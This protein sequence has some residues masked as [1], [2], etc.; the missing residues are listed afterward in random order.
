MSKKKTLFLTLLCLLI[1]ILAAAVI[2]VVFFAVYYI[3]VLK[4][5]DIVSRY[6][7]EFE[8]PPALI[9]AVI[10]T[11]SGGKT[12]KVSSKGACGLMQ[13]MPSTAEWFCNLNGYTYK[14]ENLFDAE[15]NIKLG[16]AYLNYL[17]EK[18]EVKNTVLAAYNAGEGNVKEWLK[19]NAYSSDGINLK[20]IPFTETQNYIIKVNNNNKSY[21]MLLKL[22]NL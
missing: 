9:F 10:K 18:F 1:I 20:K 7:K 12:S 21:N 15:Y 5:G 4:Y 16:C 13:I 22:K 2:T 6:S 11:E 19:Q 3:P 8:L 14:K 17:F